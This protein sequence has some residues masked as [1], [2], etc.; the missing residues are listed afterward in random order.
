MRSRFTAT[1]AAAMLAAVC[2]PAASAQDVSLTGTL[3]AGGQLPADF[4]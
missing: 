3:A 4:L 2:A 1:L